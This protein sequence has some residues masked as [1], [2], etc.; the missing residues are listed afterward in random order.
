MSRACDPTALSPLCSLARNPHSTRGTVDWSPHLIQWVSVGLSFDADIIKRTRQLVLALGECVT[1][2][3]APTMLEGERFYTLRDALIH[4]CVHIPPL[5]IRTY[6]AQVSRHTSMVS[7]LNTTESPPRLAMLRTATRTLLLRGRHRKISELLRH[8][9]PFGCPF[10]ALIAF[11]RMSVRPET[12]GPTASSARPIYHFTTARTTYGK[13]RP[14]EEVKD[15]S[16]EET[17]G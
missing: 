12:C 10:S 16:R 7:S 2:L 8:L 9:A 5:I 17:L 3:M 13:P 6:P 4:L 15:T 11:A 14:Q 1:L